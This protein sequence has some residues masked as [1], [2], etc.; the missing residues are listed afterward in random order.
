MADIE[1][2]SYRIYDIPEYLVDRHD[3]PYIAGLRSGHLK[4][5]KQAGKTSHS[6]RLYLM[7]TTSQ[8]L[9]IAAT[10]IRGHWQIENRICNWSLDVVMADDHH[11]A[12]KE[13]APANFAALRRI[14][15]S[16][17]KAN[18]DK[19]SNRGKFKKAGWNNNFLR[20]LINRF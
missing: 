3:W 19:G 13:H 11:R 5:V 10:L 6:E 2:R 4:N 18:T 9:N 1:E 12:R 8:Q 14:A 17:I 20:K 16:I 7:S 15:L